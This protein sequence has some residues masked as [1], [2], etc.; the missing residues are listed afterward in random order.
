MNGGP[1]WVVLS[2][3]LLAASA[4]PAATASHEAAN[5]HYAWRALTIP[6]VGTFPFGDTA[7][8]L[9]SPI[10]GEPPLHLGG[11]R[12]PVSSEEERFRLEHRSPAGAPLAARWV[13]LDR[14]GEVVG[15]ERFCGDTW[16]PVTGASARRVPHGTVE[17]WVVAERSLEN[18]QAYSTSSK[19]TG[20]VDAWFWYSH[21]PGQGHPEPGDGWFEGTRL[22]A[23]ADVLWLPEVARGQAPDAIKRH[24]PGPPTQDR[25][26]RVCHSTDLLGGAPLP[27]IL[28]TEP[29][30]PPLIGQQMTL[31]GSSVTACTEPDPAAPELPDAGDWGH[32]SCGWGGDAG[33]V[34]RV[35]DSR[36]GA[37]IQYRIDSP[38]P[39]WQPQPPQAG[40]PGPHP[41]GASWMGGHVAV[42]TESGSDPGGPDA[43]WECAAGD[44]NTHCFYVST[45]ECGPQAFDPTIY[46]LGSGFWFCAYP[47][48]EPPQP[49]GLGPLPSLPSID[50]DLHHCP[51]Q[52]DPT[53][54]IGD[55]MVSVCAD[56]I[57]Q[58]GGAP[59]HEV[60]PRPCTSTE[61]P[62]VRVGHSGVAYCL[63]L[64]VEVDPS[65][66]LADLDPRVDDCEDGAGVRSEAGPTH[67]GTC[68]E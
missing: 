9:D 64:D 51:D 6:Y 46:L 52:V 20:E 28:A 13:A 11:V 35:G 56:V 25:T 48:A 40:P 30:A 45:T 4:A 34:L 68:T 19:A 54:W 17:L 31:L 43:A 33:V 10:A 3:L 39:G 29:C 60:D 67:S 53:I 14:H 1:R 66:L 61:R 2:M 5:D 36:A 41:C 58:P 42:C 16:D 49:G 57:L 27:T 62:L 32:E 55:G 24:L 8:V 15:T 59:P 12:F 26:Q 23:C 22:A 63:A 21:H 44:W 50:I 38:D 7:I 47:S 37:C 18:C 65:W